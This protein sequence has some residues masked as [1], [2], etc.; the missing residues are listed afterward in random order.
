LKCTPA[1][2]I[3]GLLAFRLCEALNILGGIT[4]ETTTKKYSIIYF[5]AF[6]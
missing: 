6:A 4:G 2:S 3:E 5:L 1:G